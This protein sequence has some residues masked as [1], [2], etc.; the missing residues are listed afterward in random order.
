MMIGQALRRSA[1]GGCGVFFAALLAGSPASSFAEDF[2]YVVRVGDNP[3]NLTQRYLKSI[4][5]W[6][7]IQ[8]YN[9]IVDAT[10]MLPGSRLRIPLQWVRTTA[11]VALVVD[12]HGQ[13]EISRGEQRLPLKTGMSVPIGASLR[14]GPESSLTLEYSDGSR[15]LV[16]P[17]TELRL[18]DL[19]KL[20]ISSAQQTRV[21]LSRGR[22]EN[23]VQRQPRNSGGR[24]VIETPAAVAAVRGTR[25]RIT[26]SAD[27]VSAETL[28][29]SV[30]LAN[31]AGRTVVGEGSGSLVQTGRAPTRA[32][33]LLAAPRLDDLP[34]RVERLPIQLDFPAVRGALRY[35][36]QLTPLPRV[37]VIESDRLGEAPRA[38][39]SADLANG[40]YLLRVRAIDGNGLE[41]LDAQRQI[42]IHAHP[43][44]PLLG[45]P[46]SG[47][48]VVDEHPAFH[49]S[50]GSVP[51]DYHF[52]LASDPAFSTLL[53]DAEGVLRPSFVPAQALALGQYYWRVA[54][55]T[56]VEGEGPFSNVQHF[57]RLPASP[58]VD[59][60]RQTGDRLELSWRAGGVDERYQVQMSTDQAF[61][62]ALIEAETAK[63][64][65]SI[66]P[67]PAGAYF[68]RVRVLVPGQ[69]PSPWGETQRIEVTRNY[70]SILLIVAATLLIA[71]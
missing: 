32:V 37:A 8:E 53:V 71:F 56:T 15:S 38:T 2:V 23:G 49:W 13:A 48:V 59:S 42:A 7:A 68:V 16:G 3:W 44:P 1:G 66:D 30:L 6:P 18:V 46:A 22:L 19:S 43:E 47:G 41:G 11:A 5:Y 50:E 61:A 10:A 58:A 17:D 21:D 35:R 67:P 55:R 25:F 28:G 31:R 29:G 51:G 36:T 60:S 45:Q 40:D 34:T 63:A 57:R 9:Q 64:A 14:T 26:A 65:L 62:D 54:R 12:L 33:A 39:L 20:P 52:Q 4:N 69:P 24:F 27:A 70:W